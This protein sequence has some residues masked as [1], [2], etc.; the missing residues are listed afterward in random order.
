MEVFADDIP[1]GPVV[2]LHGL[3]ET[4][5][6]W[7]PIISRQQPLPQPTVA[8]P[9]PGHSASCTSARTAAM[10]R[11]QRFLDIYARRLDAA[12]PTGRWRLV[13]H[14]T[15]GL[16]ALQLAR[17]YPERVRD[18]LLVGSLFSGGIASARS[19]HARLTALPGFGHLAVS[20]LWRYALESP[21]NFQ[22]WG[23]MVQSGSRGA[24]PL[25]DEMRAEL[26][27]CNPLALRLMLNWV[28]GQSMRQELPLVSCPVTSVVGTKDPVVPPEHQIALLQA[29]PNARALLMETGHLPFYEAPDQF[30]DMF[31]RWLIGPRVERVLGTSS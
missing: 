6:L 7:R 23:A 17:R 27:C 19:L 15:G 9:L 4:N 13:G 24:A 25:P 18:I 8:L 14:S 20:L 5:A 2:L 11:D 30:D 22:R 12:F 31:Q 1:G 21:E 28:R 26:S 10:L 16:V 3:L 29:L